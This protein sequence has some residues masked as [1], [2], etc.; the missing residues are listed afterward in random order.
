MGLKEKIEGYLID[1]SI[2]FEEKSEN[3]WMISSQER[4]LENVALTIEDT[5][6]TITVNVMP[7]P[8]S[9]KEELFEKLLNLN[10]NEMIHGAYGIE[11]SNIVLIDTLEG[12]T[13][14]IEELQATLDSISLALAQHYKILSKYRQN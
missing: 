14:D 7:V 3:F 5:V 4:S 6:A 11:G 2:P 13:M 12:E 9:N 1:L 10:A 8:S